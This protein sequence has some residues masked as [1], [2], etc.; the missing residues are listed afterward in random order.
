[1]TE[2]HARNHVETTLAAWSRL[3]S[4]TLSYRALSNSVPIRNGTGMAD[5]R[6]VSGRFDADLVSAGLLDGLVTVPLGTLDCRGPLP[7]RTHVR[8][9]RGVESGGVTVTQANSGNNFDLDG[10]PTTAEFGATNIIVSLVIPCVS[11]REAI[12]LNDAVDHVLNTGGGA[13]AIGKCIYSAPAANDTVTV[14]L[15]VASE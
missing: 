7:C 9:R 1:M 13:D 12:Q 15:F 11:L 10:D 6:S 4:A 3:Q 5:D 14:Y 2:A 8:A